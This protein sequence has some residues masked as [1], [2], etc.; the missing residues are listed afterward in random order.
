MGRVT[1]E[2]AVSNLVTGAQAPCV[3]TD[4]VVQFSNSG[5]NPLNQLVS[6][7][8]FA[9]RAA[10]NPAPKSGSNAA[11]AKRRPK[12]V[13]PASARDRFGGIHSPDYVEV[14]RKA[15]RMCHRFHRCKRVGRQTVHHACPPRSASS[16]RQEL[17]HE[18]AIDLIDDK[19]VW[20]LCIGLRSSAESMEDS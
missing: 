14:R 20:L 5:T 1:A 8:P 17:W 16:V 4:L 10:L 11:N 7:R 15:G 18:V 12:S 6:G 9:L 3:F 19:D 13:V 2:E